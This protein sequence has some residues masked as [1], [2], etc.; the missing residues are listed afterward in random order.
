MLLK[1]DTPKLLKP[2]FRGANL[3][4]TTNNKNTALH[5]A[6]YYGQTKIVK[7]LIELEAKA[8]NNE[9]FRGKK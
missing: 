1:K 9:E 8:K 6:A 4:A 3:E 2:L 7:T 5:F